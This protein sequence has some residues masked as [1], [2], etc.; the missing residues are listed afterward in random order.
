[1]EWYW[2]VL[3]Y[4]FAASFIAGVAARGSDISEDDGEE[5][6]SIWVFCMCAWVAVAPFMV[7][8]GL[9]TLFSSQGS[10]DEEE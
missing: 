8:Y 2:W 9:A 1:M 7:G 6:I 10:E 3:L 5:L 4:I